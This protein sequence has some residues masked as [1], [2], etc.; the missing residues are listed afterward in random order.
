MVMTLRSENLRGEPLR[1]LFGVFYGWGYE[2]TETCPL[3]AQCLI[4]LSAMCID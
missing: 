3:Q 2:E 1:T 4:C